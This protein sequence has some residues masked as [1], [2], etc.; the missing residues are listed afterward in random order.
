MSSREVW[1]P[2]SDSL[3]IGSEIGYAGDPEVPVTGASTEIEADYEISRGG[4]IETLTKASD[5]L[6]DAI[7]FAKSAQTPRAYEVVSTLIKVVFDGNKDLLELSKRKVDVVAAAAKS[8]STDTHNHTHNTLILN[9]STAGLQ[10]ILSDHGVKTISRDIS[11]E[12]D[13]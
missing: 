7:S 6:D 12:D 3:G 8:G 1:D 2:L 11:T 5:A 9:G 10:K 13:A 4:I